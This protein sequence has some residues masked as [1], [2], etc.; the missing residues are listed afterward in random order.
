MNLDKVSSKTRKLKIKNTKSGSS[1]CGSA[2]TNL[3][4]IHEDAGLIPGPAQWVKDLALPGAAVQVTAW[5][6]S[7]MAVAVS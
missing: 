2:E 4:S 3:T 1:H 5:L 7:G 6:R